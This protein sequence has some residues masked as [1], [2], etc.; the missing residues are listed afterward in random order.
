MSANKPNLTAV[1][2]TS[3]SGKSSF[4]KEK[5]Q[6]FPG[7]LMIIWSPLEES[8]EYVKFVG[9]KVFKGK[10]SFPDLARA[11]ATG[12]G[13]YIYETEAD[14][15]ADLHKEFDVFCMI[16]FKSNPSR[17]EK[18]VLVLAEELA[19][20]TRPGWSPRWWKKIATQGRHRGLEV[21]GASQRPAGL[22]K[23]FLS[24]CTEVRCY[25]L[26]TPAECKYMSEIMHCTQDAINDLPY[27]HYIHRYK[28]QKKNI[29]GVQKEPKIRPK[30][31]KT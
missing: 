3:G 15:E 10:R 14:E 20:V 5:L 13:R 26:S 7:P 29:T 31:K 11:V 17:K 2:G 6:E 22:D 19:D 12:K 30:S 24:M 1:I 8:D 27:Y 28:F 4:I 18:N 9:G 25:T 23:T 16:A 21:V